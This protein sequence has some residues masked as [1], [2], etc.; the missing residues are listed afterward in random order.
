M[1]LHNIFILTII[2][3]ICAILSSIRK[4][5]YKTLEQFNYQEDGEALEKHYQKLSSNYW[6]FLKYFMSSVVS[7]SSSTESVSIADNEAAKHFMVMPNLNSHYCDSAI[8]KADTLRCNYSIDNVIKNTSFR[9][10]N[11]LYDMKTNLAYLTINKI[12]RKVNTDTYDIYMRNIQQM[13]V[14]ENIILTNPVIININKIGLFRIVS[15]RSRDEL[16]NTIIDSSDKSLVSTDTYTILHIKKLTDAESGS[17]HYETKY[18]GDLSNIIEKLGKMES[19]EIKQLAT[20]YYFSYKN[21]IKN[22][23]AASQ[24]N[25]GAIESNKYNIHN[26]FFVLDKRNINDIMNPSNNNANINQISFSVNDTLA[27]NI[28]NEALTF[29][30]SIVDSEDTFST[31]LTQHSLSNLLENMVCIIVTIKYDIMEV[32]VISLQNDPKTNMKYYVYTKDVHILS[33]N[34]TYTLPLSV[35][36]NNIKVKTY[37]P[38]LTLEKNKHLFV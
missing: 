17:F 31:D 28:T 1:I 4:K 15:I 24:I 27:I 5:Q 11:N 14:L 32:V 8:G 6:N 16:G 22:T 20:L 19:P 10:F 7:T 30:R 38:D 12:V 13:E 23:L 34:I 37:L 3:I 36:G 26:L 25:D 9:I 29:T 35:T 2:I 33:T 18:N 21:S